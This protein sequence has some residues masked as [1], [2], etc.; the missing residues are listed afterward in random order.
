MPL[1]TDVKKKFQNEMT[2]RQLKESR[3]LLDQTTRSLLENVQQITS[4]LALISQIQRSGGS[5]LSQL[6]DGHPELHAHPHELKVGYPK[7]FI[8]PPIDLNGDPERWFDLLFEDN[9]LDH[10][11]H[12][13]KKMEKYEDT[14]LF[15]FLPILQKE[16]FLSYLKKIPSITQR[17][18]FDA[19]M[20]S[21][22]NAWINNQNHAGD[23]KY[24]TAFTP[25]LAFKEANMESFFDT[26]PDGRL[27]S[28][29]RDPQN[30]FPSAYRHQLDKYG[31]INK[32]LDQWNESARSMVRNK[33]R[34]G[35]QVFMITFE[36]LVQ[37]TE[38]V[39]RHL[40]RFLEIQFDDILLTPT[41]NGI[42]IKPNTS[43]TLEAPGI[44]TSTLNRH[45]T[46][47]PGELELIQETTGDT[48][49]RALNMVTSIP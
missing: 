24:V 39:M 10:F 8:W 16:I 33:E 23:K 11:R 12:G 25:R 19:Y 45:N 1:E 31:E 17:A 47:K 18:V 44:M 43:F 42:P 46:L 27:I 37:R 28:V 6:F 3:L 30:W 38:A 9:V 2:K 22:F 40:A 32:A 4:P 7:K 35:D 20:T 34:Y 49:A 41:F 5:M 14:F 13:Y 29:V 21:Y 36:D 48:Y 26:Y 15:I